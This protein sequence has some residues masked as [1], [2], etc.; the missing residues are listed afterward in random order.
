MTIR[1]LASRTSSEDGVAALSLP[2]P[3]QLHP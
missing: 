3:P 2:S 1:L